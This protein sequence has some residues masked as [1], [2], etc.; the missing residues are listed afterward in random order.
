MGM[1]A[2]VELREHILDLAADPRLW[3]VMHRLRAQPDDILKRGIR[4]HTEP[5]ACNCFF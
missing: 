5:V 1:T 2:P 3:P 4:C